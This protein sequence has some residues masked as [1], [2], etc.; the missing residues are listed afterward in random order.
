MTHVKHPALFEANKQEFHGEA[1][2]AGDDLCPCGQGPKRPGQGNC[3]ACNALANRIYRSRQKLARE[4]ERAL[5]MHAILERQW[6]RERGIG[7]GRRRAQ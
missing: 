6:K 4:I 2:P 7:R 3:H 1:V 5:A